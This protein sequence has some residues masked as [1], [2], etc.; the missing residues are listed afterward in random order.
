MMKT[1]SSQCVLPVRATL[2]EG[3][4]W[5]ADEQRLYWVDI[6]QC[7]VHRFDPATG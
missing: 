3:A 5:F 6:L 4:C 1:F 2:G 7:E